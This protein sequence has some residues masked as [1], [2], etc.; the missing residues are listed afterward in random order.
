MNSTP[1]PAYRDLLPDFPTTET[2]VSVSQMKS[3]AKFIARNS[4]RVHPR[5]YKLLSRVIEE[6]TSFYTVFHNRALENPDPELQRSNAG[7]KFFIDALTEILEVLGGKAWIPQQKS[8]NEALNLG[9]ADQDSGMTSDEDGDASDQETQ[10][11]A[12]KQRQKT[13]LG[14]GKGKK[15]KK[16]KLTQKK[17]GIIEDVEDGGIDYQMAAWAIW[18]ELFDHRDCLQENWRKVA[19]DFLNSSIAGELS[20]VAIAAVK[21][22]ELAIFA[23]FLDKDSHN[24]YENIIQALT[25][26]N[27]ER[28]G[29][30]L[31]LARSPPKSDSTKHDEARE[32]DINVKEQIMFYAYQD[33]VDF[34]V[35]FQKNHNGKPTKSMLKTIR[36]WDP[37]F[38]LVQASE[39]QRIRWRRSFTIK[40]LYDLVNVFSSVTE[41]SMSKG[42]GPKYEAA[43]W[44]K[45]MKPWSH[46]QRLLGITEFAGFVT[47]LA[48]QNPGTEFR[49]KI[50]PHRVFQLQCSVD[51]MTVSRGWSLGIKGHIL[52]PPSKFRPTRDIDLFLDRENEQLATG[53]LLGVDALR[54][55]LDFEDGDQPK[56]LKQHYK[57]LTLLADGFD[58]WLGDTK[59]IFGSNTE[60]QSCFSKTNS[61]GLWEYSPFLCGVGLVEALELA[62][63]AGMLTWDL[64]PEPILVVHLHN[65][66]CQTGYLEGVNLYYRLSVLYKTGFFEAGHM[67][68]TSGF[69]RALDRRLNR[70]TEKRST[71]LHDSATEMEIHKLLSLEDNSCFRDKSNLVLFRESEWDP[72]RIKR[73][74]A[75]SSKWGSLDSTL[76]K[77]VTGPND[78]QH[79]HYSEFFK[80]VESSGSQSLPQDTSDQ[81]SKCEMDRATI[82]LKMRALGSKHNP[83]G[84]EMMELL[85]WDTTNEICGCDRPLSSLNFSYATVTMFR[86]C[87]KIEKELKEKNKPFC[88]KFYERTLPGTREHR[89]GLIGHVMQTQDHFSMKVVAECFTSLD[90]K[91][92]GQI[93]WEDLTCIAEEQIVVGS[94]E[95]TA[96]Q[97]EGDAKKTT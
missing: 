9:N 21:K 4:I 96:L 43:D 24:S 72:E 87:R 49:Q 83:T 39:E 22:A 85:Q 42:K 33:L 58:D 86:L 1:T 62:Y 89:L 32:I 23:D 11:E 36:D 29:G 94:E 66:L 81:L 12:P 10:P 19:Y 67:P 8:A 73:V 16:R 7:H 30:T 54:T 91:F 52:C 60:Y 25:R 2:W 82:D 41:K 18:K 59:F 55:I 26:G 95:D 38:D 57:K 45:A 34:V 70:G 48:K 53:F 3:M 92:R 44:S 97:S 51:S 47:S 37:N 31:S 14:R 61:N 69:Y 80:Q 76:S 56:R 78:E 28:K 13:R 5:I 90:S 77:E 40:W 74:I 50:S 6:R 71:T 46:H 93:Y 17:Y 68:K 35:D 64:L 88:S 20:N 65:M 75:S 79:E 63:L 27:V 84:R 15:G